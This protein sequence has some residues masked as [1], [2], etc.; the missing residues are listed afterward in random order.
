MSDPQDEFAL[1]AASTQDFEGVVAEPGTT[2]LG[3]GTGQDGG[4]S[5]DG[6]PE[7]EVPANV[8][9]VS[10]AAEAEHSA[11][12]GE[13]EHPELEDSAEG[14]GTQRRTRTTRQFPAIAFKDALGLAVAIQKQG[15]GQKV[16]RLTLFE[17]LGR[18]PE[19]GTTRRWITSSSQYGLTTGNYASEFLELTAMGFQ[20]SDPDAAQTAKLAAW[21]QLGIERPVP[22]KAIYDKYKQNRLPTPEVLRDAAMEAGV[23]K[24]SASEC[25]ETFLANAKEIGLIR[26][27]AGSEHLV[28]ID[29]V[30]E[31][32]GNDSGDYQ[33]DSEDEDERN[34]QLGALPAVPSPRAVIGDD[35]GDVCFVVSPIGSNDSEERKHAD[36]VLSALIQPA[37]KELGLR[38]VRADRISR[39]GLITRQVIDHVARAKLVIAD[40]SFGNPNVYYELALRNAIRKPVVQLIRFGDKLPF[41]VGQFRT[42]EIDMTNIYTLVPQIELYR[43]EITRQSRAAIA[44]GAS[45]ESPLSQFY[46]GFWGQ[47]AKGD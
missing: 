31:R 33:E 23:D 20:A 17:A 11:S 22:F 21:H 13:Q 4:S 9:V 7:S 5:T 8:T 14:S 45:A 27:I 29:A 36:L 37:L 34:D 44:E 41:D 18:S 3:K 38:A 35:L 30:L 6:S 16:R 15:A 28:S 1:S 12:E 43:L 47:I 24:E 2:P 26:T 40:L 10:G 19:G 32:V 46:P 39:P 25:I 42:V